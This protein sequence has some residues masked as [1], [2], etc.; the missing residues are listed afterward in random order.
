MKNGSTL[1]ARSQE[2]PGDDDETITTQVH[3]AAGDYVE[4]VV[5]QTSGAS[6]P[7]AANDVAQEIT[8]EFS[9]AWLAPGP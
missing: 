2:L 8:P 9:M 6:L 4:V 5:L 3:L 7:V 1:I